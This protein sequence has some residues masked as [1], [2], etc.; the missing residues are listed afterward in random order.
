MS[1]NRSV[2]SA[3]DAYAPNYDAYNAQNNYEM[4][5]GE[6]L[7]PQLE[8][9]GL[10]L[11]WALD[12]GCGTGRAFAPL[13]K[14][15][16]KLVG[17]DISSGMLDVARQRYD[18][19]VSLYNMDVRSIPDCESWPDNASP[20][21]DLVLM[22]NDVLNYM[23]EDG[24]LDRAFTRVKSN[25]NGPAGLFVFDANT[26]A[27]F[28]AAFGSGVAQEMTLRG[29]RW[30]GLSGKV[31]PGGIHEAEL[32]GPNL[33]P[34]VH[35]LRHWTEDQIAEALE[36]AGLRCLAVLEQSEVDGRI[37]LSS[38]RGEKSAVF[39]IVY[40]AGLAT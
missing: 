1:L 15:G 35:R 30:R 2:E 19:R 7:M 10:R 8:G 39:K 5:I 32:S 4:W 12:L 9:F 6:V 18:S 16:W 13:L 11:G 37:R 14:R 27:L 21:F 40:I 24:D 3:Y 28:K 34:H 31:F 23:V 22:L 33:K 25:L 38:Y 29:L 17:C 36:S 26:L 20:T